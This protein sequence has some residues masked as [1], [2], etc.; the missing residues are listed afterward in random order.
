MLAVAVACVLI[1]IRI[2]VDWRVTRERVA[3]LDAAQEG[4]C[5][6][7]VYPKKQSCVGDHSCPAS[8]ITIHFTGGNNAS[9]TFA[10]SGE[11]LYLKQWGDGSWHA[12][13][14]GTNLPL[15]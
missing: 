8:S 13:V 4:Y 11:T 3:I 14:V 12:G 2:V 5:W 15:N 9:A 1:V 10:D 7:H 6:E